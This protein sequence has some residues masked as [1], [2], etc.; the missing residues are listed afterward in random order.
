MAKKILVTGAAG[1]V[2]QNLIPLLVKKGYSVIALDKNEKNL[3]ILEEVNLTIDIYKTDLSEKG[4]WMDLFKD[5]DVVIDLKAQIA[6]PTKELFLR[7]N[8]Q[9]QKNILDACK[10]YKVKNLIH[11]SS[12][13]VIS[14]ANDD[15]TNTKKM[16]EELVKKS[17][18]PHTILRPPLMYG[19]FDAKHLGWLTRL[20]ERSPVFPVPGS[21]KYMRQPLYVMDLCRVIMACS[22]RK[23]QNKIYNIIGHERI[24]F[25]D[26]IRKIAKAKNLTRAIVPVPLPIFVAML[27][28]YGIFTRKTVFTKD[29]LDALMAGDDFPVD[30]WPQ[31]F[32]VKYTPFDEALQEMLASPHQKYSKRMVS[33]H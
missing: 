1:L 3:Q 27:K 20:L 16:G 31:E 2:G 24:D 28:A 13:V 5:V 11:L 12:S 30:N 18:V 8:V 26:I 32:K 9:T 19:C 25:I 29:Q 7:N 21:G 10:K 22:E 15:Y 14:V 4:K 6:A 17:S 33:P 23:P